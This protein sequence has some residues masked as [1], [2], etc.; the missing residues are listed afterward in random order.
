MDSPRTPRKTYNDVDPVTLTEVDPRHGVQLRG[1]MYDARV[2][3]ELLSRGFTQVPHSQTPMSR[4][5]IARVHAAA[6]VP[7]PPPH[8]SRAEREL[9][10]V[11]GRMERA[12]RAGRPLADADIKVYIRHHL[13]SPSELRRPYYQGAFH[14]RDPR[15]FAPH[16]WTHMDL[17]WEL[18]TIAELR[19]RFETTRSLSP[20]PHHP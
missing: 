3:R 16:E 14:A 15:Q 1:K 19:H 10:T 20:S 2:L 9:Q 11:T 8:A 18:A 4:D 17:D 6:G 5:D 12:L 7:P 13:R